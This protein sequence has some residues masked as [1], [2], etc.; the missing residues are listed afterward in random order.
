MQQPDSKLF[1]NDEKRTHTLIV[2]LHGMYHS[3]RDYI[4]PTVM[5]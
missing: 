3:A 5:H 1:M 4:P 2:N